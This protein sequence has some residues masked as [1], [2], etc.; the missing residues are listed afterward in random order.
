MIDAK[1]LPKGKKFTLVTIDD[2]KGNV[3]EEGDLALTRKDESKRAKIGDVVQITAYKLGKDIYTSGQVESIKLDASD[4]ASRIR[5]LS[6]DLTEDH[7]TIIRL[8]KKR[9]KMNSIV[10][11][12]K[13]FRKSLVSLPVGLAVEEKEELSGEVAM[14]VDWIKTHVSEAFDIL[15]GADVTDTAPKF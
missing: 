7:K 3:Y 10:L 11:S 8:E 12:I 15:T 6:E 14:L 2:P 13:A 9:Q 1:T 4:A 5:W